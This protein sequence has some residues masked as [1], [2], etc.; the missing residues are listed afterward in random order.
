MET[1]TSQDF[2]YTFIR[3]VSMTFEIPTTTTQNNNSIN[4]NNNKPCYVVP[5]IHEKSRKADTYFCV[6]IFSSE[7][8]EINFRSLSSDCS[9]F[10]NA[11]AVSHEEWEKCLKGGENNNQNLSHVQYQVRNVKT[12]KIENF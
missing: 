12:G 2:H 9:V 8:V 1:Q 5:R 6:S 11:K 7:P 3:D 10:Q 4:N